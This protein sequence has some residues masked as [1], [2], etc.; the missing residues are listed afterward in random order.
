MISGIAL[1]RLESATHPGD[2]I[3][4][5]TGDILIVVSTEYLMSSGDCSS[6]AVNLTPTFAAKLWPR[7][8]PFPGRGLIIDVAMAELFV[9]K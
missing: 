6:K 2:R 8:S 3:S 9:G 5:S 7:F 1:Q 4:S